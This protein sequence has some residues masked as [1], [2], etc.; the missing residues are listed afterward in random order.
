[1]IINQRGDGILLGYYV[2]GDNWIY[3]NLVVNAGL[4]PEWRDDPSYH[5]GIHINSGH[6]D[7][8]STA[9]HLYNN[10]LYGNGWSGAVWESQ[11]GSLLRSFRCAG[12]LEGH[13]HATPAGQA[14][15]LVNDIR[16]IPSTT[17][18]TGFIRVQR[19]IGNVV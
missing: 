15:D 7:V 19:C 17:L 5:T 14:H 9:V 2:T 11:S 3:N 6:E 16:P 18:R 13:V 10:T 1:V 8:A 12:G 4:G